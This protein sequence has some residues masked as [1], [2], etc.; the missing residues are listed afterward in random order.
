M[1]KTLDRLVSTG[2][3]KHYRQQQWAAATIRAGCQKV[4]FELYPRDESFASPS[5]TA[6]LPP[7]GLDEEAFRNSVLNDHGIM[8]AGGFGR[9]RGQIVRIGHMGPGTSEVYV[10]ATLSAVANAARKHGVKC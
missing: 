2:L 3:D 6:L 5:I 9:L 8:I 10:K 7:K 1:R 4:G